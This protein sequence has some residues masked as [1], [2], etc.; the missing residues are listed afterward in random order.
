MRVE[1]MVPDLAFRY[2]RAFSCDN[3]SGMHHGSVEGIFALKSFTYR[4]RDILG[5]GRSCSFVFFSRMA[6]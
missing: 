2:T 4:C 1:M 3:V 5:Q 6:G